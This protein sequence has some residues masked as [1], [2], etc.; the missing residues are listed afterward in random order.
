MILNYNSLDDHWLWSEVSNQRNELGKAAYTNVLVNILQIFTSL[1][2]MAV[3]NKVIP[4]QAISSLVTLAL[5]I[6]IAIVFDYAFK[7]IKS[8]IINISC[9]NIEEVLQPK[10]FKKV[11]SWD[12]QKDQNLLDQRLH[13]YEDL[14]SI[15]E[16][17]TNSSITTIINLPLF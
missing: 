17:F 9:E 3:Y 12:L 7:L 6:S 1:Y 15:I 4:N 2:V 13:C 10:L 8:R 16:L 14:E 11:L 5:G